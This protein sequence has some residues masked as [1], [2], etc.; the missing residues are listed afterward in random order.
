MKTDSGL[1]IQNLRDS[2]RVEQA[3]V[4]LRDTVREVTT[5]VIDRNE[6]GDT[7]RVAQVTERDRIRMMADVRSKK[8]EVRVVRDTIY[9]ER[10]DSVLVQGERFTMNGVGPVLPRASPL[11]DVLKWIFWIVL[12][13]T[14]LLVV[15]KITT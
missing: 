7:L 13:V 4:E 12:A 6:G 14:V 1:S 5:I 8:E 10:R 3:M 11:V 9:V 15:R 2:V